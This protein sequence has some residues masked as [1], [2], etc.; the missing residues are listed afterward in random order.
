MNDLPEEQ[1]LLIDNATAPMSP[2]KITVQG[3]LDRSLSTL[4]GAQPGTVAEGEDEIAE[5]FYGKNSG[6]E[7]KAA[8]GEIDNA[9][10][11]PG[12]RMLYYAGSPGRFVKK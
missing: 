6:E 1:R 8:E 5:E 2:G 9:P 4:D 12:K 3:N 7:T 10:M 11:S